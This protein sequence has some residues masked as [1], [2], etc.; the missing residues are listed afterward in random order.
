MSGEERQVPDAALPD[1]TLEEIDQDGALAE[2][3]D[4][5]V[6]STRAEFLLRGAVLGTG[7]IGG[8]MLEPAPAAAQ[9]AGRARDRAILQYDLVLEYLQS[10][11][12]TE[13]ER[14]RAVRP[15][16]LE[17]GRVVG[18]HER[19]HVTALKGLLGRGAVKS[20]AF[21]F[22]GVTE[23]DEAFTRTSV[24]FEDLTAAVLKHQALRIQDRSLVAAV[25][26]LHSV[27]ARHAAWVR[28]RVGLLPVT[29]AFDEPAAQSRVTR[30][31]RSTRFVVR[32]TQTRARGTPRFTG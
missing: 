18:A 28:R 20:P 22:R 7:L 9:A 5:L 31:V 6:G 21:N 13:T 15:A 24:A 2:A 14:L 19:A 23:S 32:G 8:A 29:Q 17:W 10:S 11:M 3:L 12:Y 27:E 16:T 26:T 25:L 4:G 1:V 30:L